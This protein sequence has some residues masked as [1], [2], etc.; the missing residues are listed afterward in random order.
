MSEA[1]VSI[2]EYKDRDPKTRNYIVKNI[3]SG[4]IIL[5]A[6]ISSIYILKLEKGQKLIFIQP[7]GYSEGYLARSLNI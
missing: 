4:E 6:S 1:S 3:P 7:P 5:L 2:V